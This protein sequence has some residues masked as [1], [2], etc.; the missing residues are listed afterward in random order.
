[1]LGLDPSTKL[2]LYVL[3]GLKVQYQ[4]SLQNEE[5]MSKEN[6]EIQV[7]DIENIDYTRGYIDCKN[8][9]DDEYNER[10]D[11][12]L[13]R[14]QDESRRQEN[15]KEKRRKLCNHL[16]SLFHQKLWFAPSNPK[17]PITQVTC[18]ATPEKRHHF[19]SYIPTIWAFAPTWPQGH[20]I[21]LHGCPRSVRIMVIHPKE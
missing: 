1:M 8:I 4:G 21:I 14:I 20:E 15:P 13:E 12:I 2:V 19:D 10:A 16:K 11:V 18:K 9:Q 7:I 17:R 6:S 5:R 3:M